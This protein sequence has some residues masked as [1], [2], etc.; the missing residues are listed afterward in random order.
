MLV[1][2]CAL[3]DHRRPR[4]PDDELTKEF[5]ISSKEPGNFFGC[6]QGMHMLTE[7]PAIHA[8]VFSLVVSGLI[9]AFRVDGRGAKALR[10]CTKN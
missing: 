8:F 3:Q 5:V 10:N 9:L 7:R 2:K 6:Q 1:V 4:W